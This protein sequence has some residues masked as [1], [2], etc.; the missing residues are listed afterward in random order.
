M[1]KRSHQKRIR[2]PKKI[3]LGYLENSS[4]YYLSRFA[5]SAE[6]LKRVM[7]KKVL[8]SAMHHGA[9]SEEG[10]IL[11]EDLIAR[12]LHSGLL[13]DKAYAKARANSLHDRGN[14]S[15]NIQAKLKQKGLKNDD[16][17]TAL[18]S[19]REAYENP[20]R[21]AAIRFAKRRR[22]G[23]FQKNQLDDNLRKK[24]FA[25]M[26]R[27]GFSYEIAKFIIFTKNEEDLLY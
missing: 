21:A 7:M 6:N 20:E 15:R 1:K 3:T 2:V 17:E 19:L 24:Q 4:L 11:V 13:D 9:S 5:T 14:S 18:T 27:A 8:R 22:L 10:K 16:I 23:P 26:A 25:I 12:Y